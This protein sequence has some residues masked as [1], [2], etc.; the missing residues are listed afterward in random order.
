MIRVLIADD[1]RLVRQ[2]LRALLERDRQLQITG[3]AG[4]GHEVVESLTRLVPDLVLL[5]IQM[6]GLDGL[7]V[8]QLIRERYP[9]V[10]VIVVT[11]LTDEDHVLRALKLGVHGYIIKHD[12][13]TELA[14]AIHTVMGGDLFLSSTVS[15]I[16]KPAQPA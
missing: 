2:C 16:L 15:Q 12:S 11:M 1:H 7:V 10:K 5:D 8:A 6:P 13:F 4:D 14:E 9:A 3:E